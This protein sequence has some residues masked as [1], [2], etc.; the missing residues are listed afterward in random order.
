VRDATLIIEDTRIREVRAGSG[1]LPPE[2][3]VYDA[4]PYTVVPGLIDAHTH[5]GSPSVPSLPLFRVGTPPTLGVFYAAQSAQAS[6]AAGFTTLRNMGGIEFV[7]VRQAIDGGLLP[8]PRLV[9]AGMVLMSGGHTDRLYPASYPRRPDHAA[10][11]VDQVRQR[12]RQFVLS[13]VDFIKVEATGGMIA[14][15]DTPDIRGYTDQE[16][17]AA[18]DE[19]HAFG[20]RMAVHAHSA[21]GVRRAVEAG[22]DTIEHCTWADEE[23]LE[24]VA[25][26]DAFITATCSIVEDAIRRS[27][28]GGQIV[29]ATDKRRVALEAKLKMLA[30]AR[31]LGAKVAVG[32]DA[33]GVYVPH[34]QNALE[35]ELLCRAGFTPMESLL[36]GTKVAAEA[37]GLGDR[38]G[39]LEAG[40]RADLVILARNPLDDINSLQNHGNVLQVFKDGQLVVDRLAETGKGWLRWSV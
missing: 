30:T 21:E 34:G 35:F 25:R 39:T 16:L 29:A 26:K 13:G 4:S 23:A 38:V 40:K 32:T 12:V 11:G 27:Q 22:A 14:E 24:R 5:L 28:Q 1:V 6:L 15:G 7:S 20:K 17:A 19:A 33:C 36:A 9:I 8:G 31:K 3:R 18:A 37:L 2:A 10:D